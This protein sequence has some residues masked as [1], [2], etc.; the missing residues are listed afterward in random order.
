MAY[1]RWFC[2]LLSLLGGCATDVPEDS[3]TTEPVVV[4]DCQPAPVLADQRC[5]LNADPLAPPA[6]LSQ[7]DCFA[8]LLDRTP[9]DD[10]V[11]YDVV[12]PLFSD[13]TDKGRWLVLPPNTQMSTD[14][15]GRLTFPAGSVLLKQFDVV[16]ADAVRPVE[17]RIMLRT[18]DRWALFTYV[19]REDG[20]DAD[21]GTDDMLSVDV[22]TDDGRLNWL[23]PTANE[24]GYCHGAIPE[25]LGPVE[26]QMDRDVCIGDQVVNQLDALEQWGLLD[27]NAATTTPLV[28]PSDV[29]QPIALRARSYLHANCAH[30]HRPGGWTSP[31]MDMYLDY[32]LPLV[33]THT[34]DQPVQ[35]LGQLGVDY[36]VL[37]GVPASSHLY[38][39]MRGDGLGKMPGFGERTDPEGIALIREWIATMESCDDTE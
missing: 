24:C 25:V 4:L 35:F 9:G 30:C 11:A 15:E 14:D 1:R 10:L 38:T 16:F 5:L 3:D 6:T 34:C 33:D 32:R 18:A 22:E 20:T 21:L 29:E 39:R 26:I 12:S 8:N 2:A 37:P 28:N 19:W 23:I 13:G 27:V 36:R 17:T 7:A 31:G